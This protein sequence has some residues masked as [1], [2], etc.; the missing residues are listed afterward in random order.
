MPP[1]VLFLFTPRDH[2][3]CQFQQHKQVAMVY[4]KIGLIVQNYK[5]VSWLQWEGLAVTILVQLSLK[6]G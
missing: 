3:S 1:M 5:G 4:D 6:Q 2:Y